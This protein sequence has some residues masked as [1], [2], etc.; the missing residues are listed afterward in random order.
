MQRN[1]K[2]NA[3]LTIASKE[4]V[5]NW[6]NRQIRCCFKETFI[7]WLLNGGL[8]KKI[9]SI[10]LTLFCSVV[11]FQ[12][13]ALNRVVT[14]DEAFSLVKKV[15]ASALEGQQQRVEAIRVGDSKVEINVADLPPGLYVISY[16]VN[17]QIV[18]SKKFNK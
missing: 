9:F 6:K 7:V 10:L 14:K 12:G 4:A 2:L 17:S 16:I 13:M 5:K 8:M 3:Y 11:L 15:I 1:D 18:D